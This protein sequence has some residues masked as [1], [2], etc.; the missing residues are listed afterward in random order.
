MF[1]TLKS[2]LYETKKEATNAS[3][4]KN[5]SEMNIFEKEMFK[6]EHRILSGNGAEKL[7]STGN[8]FVDDFGSLAKYRD[9]RSFK[10]IFETMDT[11]W[12]INPLN[13]L[14]LLGYIRMISRDTRYM[15]DV[16][17]GS[18]GQGLKHE[19]LG[20]L[21]WVAVKHPEVFKKNLLLF[22]SIGSWQDL[23]K[24]LEYDLSYIH[25]GRN[26]VLDWKWI[27]A[28]IGNYLQDPSQCDLIKKYLPT[29]KNAKSCTTLHSQCTNYIGKYLAKTWFGD[30]D[31]DKL[32]SQYRKLKSSGNGHSWQQAIS[33]Q[34]YSALNFNA[35]SGRALNK[36]VN[37]K[38]L[39][40]HNL[41]KEY[42]KW[43]LSKPVVNY[44]GYVYELMSPVNAGM[45]SYQFHTIN[46]QFEMLVEKAKINNPM[47]LIVAID[48]SGSMQSKACGT[49]VS[50]LD[51]AKSMGL[52]FSSILDGKFADSFIE[53]ESDI[54][55]HNWSRYHKTRITW[56][57]VAKKYDVADDG[58]Y[59][60]TTPC[61][62]FM[63][64]LSGYCGSTNFIKIADLFVK[65]REQGYEESEFPEGLLCV[66]DGEFDN[67][68]TK[69]NFEEFRH[70]ML[71]GG[72]SEEFVKNFKLILWDVPNGYYYRNTG[73]K[74]ETL[75][76]CENCYYLSGFDPSAIAFLFNKE[77][78]DNV[79]Q[80]PK[81]AEELMEAALN[82]DILNQ[83]TI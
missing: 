48:S 16:F 75:A 34:D 24:L 17:K 71:K 14:K 1:D 72:F 66:S 67:C 27:A 74:F 19:T 62:K 73:A 68:G 80:T 63:N 55:L 56:D 11:M 65:L 33:R 30:A 70:R 54:H 69:A 57:W 36:L 2:S 18:K 10:E 78:K 53:F 22:I 59:E 61:E 6:E 15:E 45:K 37:G 64:P 32:Y 26:H 29:I 25:N 13:T 20:R 50:A 7:S 35:I 47:K 8:I 51:V 21:M 77:V 12:S 23:F 43:V 31:K 3:A 52:F 83:I 38:F 44:T 76:D 5:L 42:E 81:T 46:K 28:F 58:Y 9:P 49:N 41:E 82:Q 39:E 4:V 40:N 60:A 79:I